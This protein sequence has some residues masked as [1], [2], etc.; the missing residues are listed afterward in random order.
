[1]KK[2]L[3]AGETYPVAEMLWNY[4]LY[5]PS[6]V[7]ITDSEI[8]FSAAALKTCLGIDTYEGHK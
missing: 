5:L 6:G 3:F 4:G 7:G 8:D 1:M 2:G